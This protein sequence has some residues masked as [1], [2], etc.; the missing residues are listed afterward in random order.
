MYCK[1]TQT[2]TT[3]I[4]IALCLCCQEYARQMNSPQK[5]FLTKV[6][7]NSFYHFIPIN[8]INL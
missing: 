3:I 5:I 2:L 6:T 7:D 1:H 8:V 4:F